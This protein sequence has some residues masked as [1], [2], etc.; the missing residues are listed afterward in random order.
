MSVLT[1]VLLAKSSVPPE[2]SSSDGTQR[3]PMLLDVKMAYMRSLGEAARCALGSDSMRRETSM[4]KWPG[5]SGNRWV[6]PE[7]TR[8]RLVSVPWMFYCSLL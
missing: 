4:I 1:P 8:S 5:V 7:G 2:R 6:W 3:E